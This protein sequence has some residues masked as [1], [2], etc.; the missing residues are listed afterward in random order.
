M[1]APATRQ[2]VIE[3]IDLKIRNINALNIMI[4]SLAGF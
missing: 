2:K 3:L 4:I 1:I